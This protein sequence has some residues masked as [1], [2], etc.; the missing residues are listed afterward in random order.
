MFT[1]Q[2]RLDNL[3]RF[4]SK[5]EAEVEAIL[6]AWQETNDEAFLDLYASK[7]MQLKTLYELYDEMIHEFAH[8][9]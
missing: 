1:I 2:H 9:S 3:Q 4:I 8:I 6:E 5:R 7:Q